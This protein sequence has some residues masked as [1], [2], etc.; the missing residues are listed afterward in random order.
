MLRGS[1]G[2]EW[3]HMVWFSQSQQL[4]SKHPRD[5]DPSRSHVIRMCSLPGAMVWQIIVAMTK[6]MAAPSTQGDL[7]VIKKYEMITLIYNRKSCRL[8]L[9]SF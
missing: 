6:K 2:F 3:N 7:D 4:C 1:A 9:L 5:H 8:D